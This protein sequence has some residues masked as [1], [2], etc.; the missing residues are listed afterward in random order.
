MD[1][2]LG[3]IASDVTKRGI[4]GFGEEVW[5][6]HVET[7][8]GFWNSLVRFFGAL[9][10]SGSRV[11]QDGLVADG[12]M[13]QKIVKEGLKSGS[14]NYEIVYKLIQGGAVLVKTEDFALVAKE[15]D[16]LIE[17][18]KARTKIER[19]I[20]YLRYRL[21]KNQ[22]LKKRDRFIADRINQTLSSGE[23]GI[24]FIGAY[25]NIIPMLDKDIQIKEIKEIEKIRDYQKAF[26]YSRKDKERFE[27]LSRYLVS[28]I[29]IGEA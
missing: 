11:Y 2:D 10:V 21:I 28:P 12:D 25:H 9:E 3:S 5:E 26:L 6:K 19:L 14:K 4:T 7:V 18:T 1:V 13:G 29:D 8:E 16:H 23:T 24:L 22:L 15:R 17:L 20:A 27:A